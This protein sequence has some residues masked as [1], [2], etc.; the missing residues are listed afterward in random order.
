M[1]L[2]MILA[3]LDGLDENIA[4]LYEKSEDGSFIL[5]VEGAVPKAKVDEF[6]QNNIDLQNKLKVFTDANITVDE[7]TSLRELKQKVDE[8]QLVDTG[9]ID[10]AVQNR[11][12]QLKQEHEAALTAKD[13]ALS[14]LT[15]HLQSTMLSSELG[16]VAIKAGVAESAMDDVLLRAQGVYKYKNDRLVPLDGKGEVI[17]GKNGVDPMSMSEWLTGLS[18]TAPHLFSGSSGGGPKK[19][20]QTGDVSK[21]SAT[22]KIAA[23]ITQ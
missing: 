7:V 15:A 9:K 18:A 11:V 23:G 16:K 2:K 22:Q 6:R 14:D 8:K 20:G 21:M 3:N 13:Q 4:K 17:Y 12:T 5:Q 10:E 19:P 1:A